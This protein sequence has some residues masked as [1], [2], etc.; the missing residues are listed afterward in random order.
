MKD[1]R[2]F[3]VISRTLS[4]QTEWTLTEEP[5]TVWNL[6]VPLSAGAEAIID[7]ECK[8]ERPPSSNRGTVALPLTL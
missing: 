1:S 4:L 6:V 7:S 2:D 5:S 8:L 3:V